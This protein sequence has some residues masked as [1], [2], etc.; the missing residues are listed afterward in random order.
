MV[1][2][3]V[4]E[5]VPYDLAALYE[6]RFAEC[7]PYLVYLRVLWERY[8]QELLDDAGPTGRI[9]LTRFQNDGIGRAALQV[10]DDEDLLAGILGD[11]QLAGAPLDVGD[12]IAGALVVD[13]VE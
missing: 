4:A 5:A 11:I 10:F 1:R 12:G 3:P 13:A 7:S 8:G 9:Q 2:G 6:A